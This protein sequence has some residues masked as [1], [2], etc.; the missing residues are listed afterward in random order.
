MDNG[1]LKMRTA[2]CV[3]LQDGK[4]FLPILNIPLLNRVSAK[5]EGKRRILPSWP[6]W[7]ALTGP[8][9]AMTD[10]GFFG[11]LIVKTIR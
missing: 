8:S 9:S 4:M 7:K 10:V 6:H 11:N 2:P 1:S 5:R 3:G